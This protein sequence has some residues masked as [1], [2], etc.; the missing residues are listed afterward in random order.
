MSLTLTTLLHH[1]L[2]ISG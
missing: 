2:F 1:K